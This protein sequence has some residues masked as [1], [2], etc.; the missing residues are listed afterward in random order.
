MEEVVLC[1]VK[2]FCLEILKI[3]Q[4]LTALRVRANRSKSLETLYDLGSLVPG[5]FSEMTISALMSFPSLRL[6]R[7]PHLLTHNTP[8]R[9]AASQHESIKTTI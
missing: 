2:D 9:L 4:Y 1:N 7:G 5:I 3:P 8:H 6:S